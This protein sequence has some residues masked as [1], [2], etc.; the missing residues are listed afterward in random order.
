MSSKAEQTHSIT[1]ADTVLVIAINADL[2][3]YV[4][5]RAEIRILKHVID[6]CIF[7]ILSNIAF[8]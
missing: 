3:G 2:R 5:K 7:Q 8:Q 1:P 4:G 6:R